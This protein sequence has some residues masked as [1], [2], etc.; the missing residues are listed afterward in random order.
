MLPLEPVPATI[1]MLSHSALSLQLSPHIPSPQPSP[2]I[3]S[4]QPSPS[5]PLSPLPF[6]S[7]P[8]PQSTSSSPLSPFNLVDNVRGVQLPATNETVVWRNGY[9]TVLP[10]WHHDAS[11][12]THLSTAPAAGPESP[13]F[14]FLEKSMPSSDLRQRIREGLTRGKM[15]VIQDCQDVSNFTFNEE[16]SRN[17]FNLFSNTRVDIHD[18]YKRAEDFSNP[19]V[20]G[21]IHDVLKTLHDPAQSQYVLACY[22]TQQGL[23]SGLE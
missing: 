14:L 10:H 17:E 8:L 9:H 4:P 3:P 7:L 21:T 18:L 5:T 12:V 2:H 19:Y 16:G 11:F 1:L 15:V 22:N 6:S 13:N 20:K 23:L